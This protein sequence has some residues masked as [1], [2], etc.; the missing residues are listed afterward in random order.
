MT[1][2]CLTCSCVAPGETLEY[3]YRPTNE[4]VEVL[5]IANLGQERPGDPG[6]GMRLYRVRFPDN[7]LGQ[8]DDRDLLERGPNGLR[9]FR[10]TTALIA[11]AAALTARLTRKA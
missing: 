9:S 8:A 7:S 6:H 4:T 10:P 1:R 11:E 3:V 2:H 5:G